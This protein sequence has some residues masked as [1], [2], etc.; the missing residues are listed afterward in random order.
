MSACRLVALPEENA[1]NMYGH[2]NNNHGRGHGCGRGRD[3]VKV[4][5][6]DAAT[7]QKSHGSC[8][9]CGSTVHFSR[10][11]C[12]PAHLFQIYQESI[13]GKGKK[14]TSLTILNALV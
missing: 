6:H 5:R 14:Q 8:Y 2:R 13:K 12:T 10:T 9:K 3:K 1:M 7:S 11:C 4:V